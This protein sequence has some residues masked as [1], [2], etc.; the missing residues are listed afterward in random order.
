MEISSNKNRDGRETSREREK[1]TYKNYKRR[2]ERRV[3][4]ER[5]NGIA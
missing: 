2:T 3:R 1:Y 4:K 5:K